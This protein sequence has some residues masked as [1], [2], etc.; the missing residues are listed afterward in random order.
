[1]GGLQTLLTGYV[2]FSYFLPLLGAFLLFLV[3]IFLLG[4]VFCSWVCPVGAIVDGFDKVVATYM[5][6]I[7]A[8]REKR[9]Q[10]SK[11]KE[12]AKKTNAAACLPCP[13]TRILNKMFGGT[14]A[15]GVLVFS[16]VGSVVFRFPVFCSVCPIGVVSRGMFHLKAWTVLAS[17]S[18]KILPI[19][20]ELS[21][22]P[23]IAVLLSLRE[24]RYWCRKICPVGATLNLAGSVSPL[25]KPKVREEGCVMKKCPT[26]CDDYH[27]GYCGT[28]RQL[29]AKRCESVCPQGI[30]LVEDG[31]LFRC[32]KCFECYIECEKDAVKIDVV[33]KSDAYT[34]FKRLL[35]R[36]PNAQDS[37]Q[38]V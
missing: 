28:C 35:K 30:N 3:P 6:G 13:F 36:K 12:A 15:N 37:P 23:V 8:K 9:L 2:N 19:I 38:K 22:I 32:T 4:N 31:S 7:D 21:V 16:L 33:G 10:R 24:K 1:V 11:A 25:L 14:A 17:V 18:Q 5:R 29:D 27:L 34:A 20:L 26:T